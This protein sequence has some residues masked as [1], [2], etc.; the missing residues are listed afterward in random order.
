MVRWWVVLGMVAALAGVPGVAA[1][2]LLSHEMSAVGDQSQAYEL[3]SIAGASLKTSCAGPSGASV[4]VSWMGDRSA[5][6][7]DGFEIL[8]SE[9]RGEFVSVGVLPVAGPARYSDD[10]VAAGTTY[11]YAVR[12]V[13]SGWNGEDSMT[14]P[15]TVPVCG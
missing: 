15:V 14:A 4:T 10:S 13:S 2:R 12:A 7:T 6:L 9:R 5:V 11:T 8:R 3:D 1:A